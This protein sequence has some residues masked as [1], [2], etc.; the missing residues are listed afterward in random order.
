M[1]EKWT[2]DQALIFL[3]VGLAVIFVEVG[4]LLS[5]FFACSRGSRKAK[6]RASTFTS[7]QTLSPFSESDHDF[8]KNLRPH[9]SRIPRQAFDLSFYE[10]VVALFIGMGIENRMHATGTTFG[11]KS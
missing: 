11:A 8:G 4:A 5:T 2:Q 3:T 9:L 1:L 6:S 10:S 7:T